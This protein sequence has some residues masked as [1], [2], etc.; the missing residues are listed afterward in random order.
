MLW[1]Q[2][3]QSTQK[4]PGTLVVIALFAFLFRASCPSPFG[5]HFVRSKIFQKFLSPTISSSLWF[6]KDTGFLR[7]QE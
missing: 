5:P 6:A 1:P 3:T 7:S 4:A 2:K